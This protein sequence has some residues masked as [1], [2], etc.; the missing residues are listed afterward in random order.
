MRALSSAKATNKSCMNW[1]T[2]L[3]DVPKQIENY[4]Y[5]PVRFNGKPQIQSSG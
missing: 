3:D 4:A 1:T 5:R 2:D